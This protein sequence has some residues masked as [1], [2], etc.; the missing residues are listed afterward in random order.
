MIQGLGARLLRL[1][2]PDKKNPYEMWRQLNQRYVV[3]NV[4]TQIQLLGELSQTQYRNQSMD[5][6]TDELENSFN[7]LADMNE[8]VRGNMQVAM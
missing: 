7:R 5:E 3:A 8:M 2:L 6:Y 4:T 1:C